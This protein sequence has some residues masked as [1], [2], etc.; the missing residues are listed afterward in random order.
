MSKRYESK[1]IR[2]KKAVLK[3]HILRSTIIC[4]AIAVILI[5]LVISFLIGIYSD[6]LAIFGELYSYLASLSVGMINGF[7]VLISVILIAF[8]FFT[9]IAVA[10]YREYQREVASWWEVIAVL[11]ITVLL[12]VFFDIITFIPL[13][14]TSIGCILIVVFLYIIQSPPEIE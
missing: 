2:K 8:N 7:S 3:S 4:G 14:L 11:G 6:E 1:E 5:I 13:I 9:I 12:S 10:N